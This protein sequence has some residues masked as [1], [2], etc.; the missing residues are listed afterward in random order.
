IWHSCRHAAPA[1]ALAAGLG[2]VLTLSDPGPGLILGLRTAAAEI[3]TSFSALYDFRQAGLQCAALSGLVLL[4]AAP[5]ACLPAPRLASATLARQSAGLRP[6][7]RASALALTL[8]V[9]LGSALPLVGLTLP[10]L[11][12]RTDFPRPWQQVSRTGANTLLYA[13]GA[14]GVA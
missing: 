9:L 7:R 13:A 12:G 3:L 6:I 1:A 2:G 10:L 14:G 8:P 4:L 11:E 5:L